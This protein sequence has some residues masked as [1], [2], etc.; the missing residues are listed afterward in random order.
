M[1]SNIFRAIFQKLSS[2]GIRK[3]H[4]TYEQGLIRLTNKS[5][6]TILLIV[7]LVLLPLA[8]I[9]QQTLP[10]LF[11]NSIF[12]PVTLVFNNAGR[13]TL[14]RHYL[15]FLLYSLIFMVS[16]FRGRES[17]ALFLL[18]PAILLTLIF[19]YKKKGLYLHFALSITVIV[20]TFYAHY[21]IQPIRPYSPALLSL[22]YPFH[23]F[24]SLALTFFFINFFY[25]L[26]AEYQKELMELNFTKNKI[27]S[28]ISH[29]LRS[30]LNSLKGV[31]GL[32]NKRQITQDEFYRLAG[33][34]GKNVEN[35]SYMMDNLLHWAFTQM[36]GF[37]PSP[38]TF[39][40]QQIA[41]EQVTLFAEAARQ[42]GILLQN[43]ITEPV[44]VY[45]DVNHIRLIL[46]NL[47]NNAIKFSNKGGLVCIKATIDTG[48]VTIFVT[49]TGVGIPEEYLKKILKSNPQASATGTRGETGTGLGL[50]L[51]K[52]M[53]AYNGGQLWISSKPGE[54][55][56]FSFSLP[57]QKQGNIKQEYAEPGKGKL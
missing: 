53:I 21:T 8:L 12:F 48:Y 14:A 41:E 17:G 27:I 33:D 38:S 5:A 45:A 24:I 49:D 23:L 44:A 36:K 54:G 28:I 25:A 50:L 22:V 7:N 46:R 20:L 15:I 10:I 13:Y 9:N 43:Y 31:L 39:S 56:T 11:I 19:F 30:P 18:I 47:I 42:K 26:N 35:L 40:L 16:I 6:L 57:H 52:E 1:R 55:S 37:T 34:L 2:A 29:D 3:E 51:C 32:L 4:S